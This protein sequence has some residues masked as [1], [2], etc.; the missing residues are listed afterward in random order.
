MSVGI[1]LL[2]IQTNQLNHFSRTGRINS[3]CF[4]YISTRMSLLIGAKLFRNLKKNCIFLISIFCPDNFS[5]TGS[6]FSNKFVLDF[7]F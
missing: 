4:G 5:V 7:Y 2:K 3:D 1:N 6:F